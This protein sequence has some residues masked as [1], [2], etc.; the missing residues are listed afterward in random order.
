MHRQNYDYSSS[1][2]IVD[3]LEEAER[4]KEDRTATNIHST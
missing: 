1:Q 4:A 2:D 3:I